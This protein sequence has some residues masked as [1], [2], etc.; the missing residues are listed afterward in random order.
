MSRVADHLIEIAE[1]VV[2][3]LATDDDDI[4]DLV[5]TWLVENEIEMVPSI[6][7]IATTFQTQHMCPQCL[8]YS[9]NPATCACVTRD[10]I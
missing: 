6:P 9:E 5:M 3:H 4:F 8:T 10:H 1:D 7:F 2:K